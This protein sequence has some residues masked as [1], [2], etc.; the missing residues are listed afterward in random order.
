SL[1]SRCVNGKRESSSAWPRG[2]DSARVHEAPAARTLR[3]IESEAGVSEG[4]NSQSG[5]DR[6]KMR[7]RAG[8]KRCIPGLGPVA[9]DGDPKAKGALVQGSHFGFERSV[10]ETSPKCVALK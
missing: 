7:P 5:A 3:D 2:N 4:A 9:E 8:L 10:K 6:E 1:P